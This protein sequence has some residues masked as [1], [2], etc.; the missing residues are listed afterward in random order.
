MPIEIIKPVELITNV[1]Y[2]LE[3]DYIDTP[4]CGFSFTCD[5][6]GNVLVSELNPAALANYEMCQVSTKLVCKGVQRYVTNYTDPAIG[7]CY[8]GAEVWLGGFTNTC[9]SCGADYNWNGTRLAP[10]SQ[11]GEETGETVSDILRIP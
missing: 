9:D 4:G 8:C 7:R 10:R 3:Y 1:E 6:D 2:S 11:W 5:E